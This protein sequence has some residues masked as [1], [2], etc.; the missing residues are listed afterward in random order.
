MA[1]KTNYIKHGEELFEV[2]PPTPTET[3]RGGI[4][5]SPKT[6]DENV[7]VKLG[8]DGK[9]YVPAY[10]TPDEEGN[11][12]SYVEQILTDE[13]K[14]QAR[15]NIEAVGN[16]DVIDN[17]TSTDTDKPLSAAQGNILNQKLVA[18]EESIGKALVELSN[19]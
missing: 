14:A 4:I 19:I 17:L 7:E 6:D 5:A 12:V 1:L 8:E 2:I 9:L 16:G 3:E 11:S 18:I 15:A 10:V 13:Q